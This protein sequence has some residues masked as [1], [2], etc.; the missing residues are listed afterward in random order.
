MRMKFLWIFVAAAIVYCI[1]KPCL[2]GETRKKFNP[3][4]AVKDILAA[5]K[6]AK[7]SG[8]AKQVSIADMKKKYIG[9][10]VSSKGKIHS[11]NSTREGGVSI[12]VTVAT[13]K[14]GGSR[15]YV[16]VSL[17]DKMT[18]AATELERGQSYTIVGVITKTKN[19]TLQTGTADG[20]WIVLDAVPVVDD[21]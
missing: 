12:N 16:M 11:V 14:K 3:K 19:C 4:A 5:S 18:D 15:V 1:A 21:E 17:I 20:G 2:A 10:L 8:L 9:M 7:K 6:K 13:L